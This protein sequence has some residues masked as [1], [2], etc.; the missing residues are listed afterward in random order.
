MTSLKSYVWKYQVPFFVLW[1][2]HCQTVFPHVH[3]EKVICNCLPGRSSH[4][5]KRLEPGLFESAQTPKSVRNW[6]CNLPH[7]FPAM[8]R[9]SSSIIS[10]S[11]REPT[12]PFLGAQSRWTALRA[13][14]W[15]DLWGTRA[16]G[17][18]KKAGV[19]ILPVSF[20]M[21]Y[22]GVAASLNQNHSSGQAAPSMWPLLP[23]PSKHI[24]PLQ[25]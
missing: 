22:C 23:G 17:G 25:A 24:L 4:L 11:P 15:A 1:L 6:T 5:F 16:R 8:L 18:R 19:F 14:G 2:N 12:L 3:L 10:H 20:S 13:S 9:N 7:H 21:A